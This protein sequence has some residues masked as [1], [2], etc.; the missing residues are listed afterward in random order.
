MKYSL[1]LPILVALISAVLSAKLRD[2]IFQLLIQDTSISPTSTT[3]I[4]PSADPDPPL[5]I[6]M[7]NSSYT[8]SQTIGTNSPV[9]CF[10]NGGSEKIFFQHLVFEDCTLLFY[11]M[12]LNPDILR[13]VSYPYKYGDSWRRKSGTCIMGL[14][15]RAG[16]GRGSISEYDIGVMLAKVVEQCVG[17]ATDYRGG[18]ADL[19]GVGPGW[20]VT[21]YAEGTTM[22]GTQPVAED[23]ESGIN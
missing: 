9:K 22:V 14:T 2:D 7:H 13:K 20:A 6:E 1:L 19:N 4:K 12:F 8:E 21:V 17:P 3:A 23:V 5:P 16:G 18:S 11:Q 10:R 15:S